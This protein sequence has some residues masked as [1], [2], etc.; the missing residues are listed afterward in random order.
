MF[1]R[2]ET[3][4]AERVLNPASLSSWFCGGLGTVLYRDAFIDRSL[5][6]L[7][8]RSTERKDRGQRSTIPHRVSNCSKAICE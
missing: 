7:I 3:V 6:W 4:D 2:K 1:L 8:E 5:V